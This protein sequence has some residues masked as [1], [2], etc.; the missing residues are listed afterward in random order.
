MQPSEDEDMGPAGTC[1]QISSAGQRGVW[2]T[3]GFWW[4]S[5]LWTRSSQSEASQPSILLAPGW[6]WLGDGEGKQAPFFSHRERRTVH[7]GTLPQI[8]KARSRIPFTS[9]PLKQNKIKPF[10][11]HSRP[12]TWTLFVL[13]CPPGA[14]GGTWLLEHEMAPSGWHFKIS[15][16]YFFF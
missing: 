6:A 12:L 15:V 10:L 2:Q 4:R 16:S 8:T 14:I 13:Q 7:M 5:E 11:D 9:V 3:H 1:W